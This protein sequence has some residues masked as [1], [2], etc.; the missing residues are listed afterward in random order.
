[1]ERG[2]P[3][4]KPEWLKSPNG[5]PVV[6]SRPREKFVV[7]LV[8]EHEFERSNRER[9]RDRDFDLLDRSACNGFHD[10]SES[11]LSSQSEN[12]ILRQSRSVVSGE[13]PGSNSIN[14][15]HSKDSIVGASFEK[16]FPTLGS[17]EKN[18]RQDVGW[19]PSP[20]G[21]TPIQSISLGLESRDSA[22]ATIPT[23]TGANGLGFSSISRA[24]SVSQVPA[25]VIA[26]TGLS[27]NTGL[28][29]AETVAQAPSRARTPPQL[30]SD[31]QRSE[32]L[33]RRQCEQLRP[34]MPSTPRTSVSNLSDK[35][36]NKVSR[37]G[38]SS[39]APKTEQKFSQ[40]VTCLH[41]PL[42]SDFARPS[43]VGS[44]LVLNRERNGLSPTTKGN[45]NISKA[46]S[47]VGLA[48]SAS[49]NSPNLQKPK[50][51][52]KVTITFSPQGSFGERRSHLQA[53]DRLEFFNSIRNKTVNSSSGMP[54]PGSVSN[55]SS[56]VDSREQAVNNKK[57][58]IADC[59]LKCS[60]NGKCVCEDKDACEES[61][62][63]LHVNEDANAI[64]EP[65]DPE[66]E[67]FL[68]SLGW[69]QNAA[70][71]SKKAVGSEKTYG[72]STGDAVDLVHEFAQ[73]SYAGLISTVQ[74]GNGDVDRSDSRARNIS[75]IAIKCCR[76]HTESPA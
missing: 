18:R 38:D 26:S 62:R 6:G 61:E 13:G 32:K 10:H 41:T 35:S 59:E 27:T 16:E 75:W 73:T 12:D 28:N 60:E 65:V 44:F 2:E 67:A 19:V 64:S 11:F 33:T 43:Q 17:E 31:I 71:D 40:H 49:L 56:F 8:E 69:D 51:D 47:P 74:R 39:T 58:G 4:F 50:A 24:A 72:G 54:E 9:D 1:M 70:V 21:N 34:V 37:S 48:A 52:S 30:S 68:R 46:A 53:K 29:M 55:L 3:A 7:F 23:T 14:G 76:L 42:K 57:D 36:R 22:V 45:S 66:E 15:V 63:L 20:G 25:P 5:K